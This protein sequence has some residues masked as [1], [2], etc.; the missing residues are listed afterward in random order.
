MLSTIASRCNKTNIELLE[1][2]K[3]YDILSARYGGSDLTK[4]KLCASLS[5]GKLGRAFELY[6]KDNLL[7]LYD[8]AINLFGNM[9]KSS[10]ILS[11]SNFIITNK[12]SIKDIFNFMLLIVRDMLVINSGSDNQL[13][14]YNTSENIKTLASTFSTEA[15]LYINDKIVAAQKSLA[16]NCNI[17]A[18]TDMVLMS[19]LEG[20]Y[21]WQ[22]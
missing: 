5:E 21:K 22:K 13:M 15:L 18:V 12:D 19:I 3:V 14:C 6:E 1:K 7:K 8:F 10:D 20:K 11:H 17:T 4:I 9:K 2:Q 16:A